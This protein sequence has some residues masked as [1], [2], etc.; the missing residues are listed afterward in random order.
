MMGTEGGASAL[1]VG[2]RLV[3]Y[4]IAADI[5]DLPAIRPDFDEIVF[6]PWLRSLVQRE[7]EGRTLRSC[8]EVRPNNWG[9]HCGASRIAVAAYLGDQVEMALAAAV[10]QGWLGDRQSHAGF[11]FDSE[12][13]SWISDACLAL[14][15]EC[16]P[17]PINPPGATLGGH[18]VDG[19]VVDDQ[20][21][22]GA[23]SWPPLY[24]FYS[25]GALGGAVVFFLI[26]NFGSWLTPIF[27]YERSLEGLLQC[28]AAGVPFFRAMLVGDL[29]YVP[30]LFG[31]FALAERAVPALAPAQAAGK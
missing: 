14:A 29:I 8:H 5:I 6:R 30:L 15:P 13:F 16:Q 21:R 26:S 4:V 9:T 31:V 7:F 10:F 17:R 28:Y 25:Y 19:V 22:A 2:R 23:F 24:T 11:K 12:A 18:N 20:R 27:G 1:A 3:S